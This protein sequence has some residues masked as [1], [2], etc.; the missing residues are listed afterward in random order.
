MMKNDDEKLY[1]PTLVSSA[2]LVLQAF[3]LSLSKNT[4][5]FTAIIEIGLN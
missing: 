3:R 5:N 2:E 4:P 1:L